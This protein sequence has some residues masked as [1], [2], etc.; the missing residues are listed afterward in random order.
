MVIQPF[1]FTVDFK[2]AYLGLYLEINTENI[3]LRLSGLLPGS[4]FILF[5]AFVVTPLI[6]FLRLCVFAFRTNIP[7]MLFV[8]SKALTDIPALTTRSVRYLSFNVMI[9]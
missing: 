1:A 6:S 5:R 7:V 4:F 3:S 2:R 8:I 9:N